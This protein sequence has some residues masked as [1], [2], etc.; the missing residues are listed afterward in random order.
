MCNYVILCW[1][2][3][4]RLDISLMLFLCVAM[5]YYIDVIDVALIYPRCDFYV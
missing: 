1:R 4:R 5:W 3:W 2:H